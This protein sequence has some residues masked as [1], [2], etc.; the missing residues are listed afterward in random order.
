MSVEDEKRVKARRRMRGIAT[1]FI[2][3]S[4]IGGVAAIGLF[5]IG[6]WEL[7]ADSVFETVLL[8]VG[9]LVSAVA[10]WNGSRFAAVF[11]ILLLGL[12]PALAAMGQAEIEI[13]DI[14]RS[15]IY[16]ILALIMLTSAIQ[17]HR[18]SPQA[19]QPLGGSSVLRWGGKVLMGTV[20]AF[21]GF[22]AGVLVFANNTAVADGSDLSQAHREWLVEREFLLPSEKTL[23]FYLDGQI[24]IDEG[25]TLLTDEYVG[26][27]WQEDGTVESVW[28]KLG[29]ICRVDT[30]S[31][32]SALADAIYSVHGPGDD[33]W[34]QLWLS[35]EDNMHKRLIAQMNLLNGRKMRS[36]IQMF[37]DENRPIDWTEVAA[38][39]GISPDIVGS[40]DIKQEHI[41]WLF[42]NE[43]LLS[44]E[45]LMQFYSYG[46]YAISEG[47]S[48]LTDQFFG[49]W[50]KSGGEI[51]SVWI[52]IGSICR[53][54]PIETGRDAE[55]DRYLLS[56]LDDAW[57]K[58]SLPAAGD[59][60]E[61]LVDQARAMNA[62]QMTQETRQSCDDAEN[63]SKTE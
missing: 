18:L 14:V 61:V 59:Q 57:I 16:I 60:S 10:A 17:Y 12:N 51:E 24:S 38:K 37:C 7:N 31:E 62:E 29:Q 58:L 11:L 41:D 42:E 25:G 35:I 20:V 49:G 54:D 55:T 22:G 5:A 2:V 32:G 27:W 33:N 52:E 21:F 1:I 19:S 63:A 9:M 48:L 46:T 45:R 34:V 39:N 40:E 30:L 44:D 28:L 53:I 13:T 43:F 8:V 3:I 23:Y 36:E 4:L 15:I 6:R 56:G 50:Y 47:G 26:A